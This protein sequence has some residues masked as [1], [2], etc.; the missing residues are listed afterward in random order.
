MMPTNW[1]TDNSLLQN[2][3]ISSPSNAFCSNYFTTIF[4][5]EELVFMESWEWASLGRLGIFVQAT[6][7]AGA[8]VYQVC[9][10]L[11]YSK[12][13][14]IDFEVSGRLLYWKYDLIA[15][16]SVSVSIA[17]YSMS[18]SVYPDRRSIVETNVYVEGTVLYLC[19]IQVWLRLLW[20]FCTTGHCVGKFWNCHY[21]VSHV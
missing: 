9:C 4:L 8:C 1:N 21:Y 13:D 3:S 10:R 17:Y 5:N 15:L 18:Q 20:W 6:S 19:A 11:L 12:Y 14:L 16:C 7:S 2:Y